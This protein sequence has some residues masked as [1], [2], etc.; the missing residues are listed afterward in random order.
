MALVRKFRKTT[1]PPVPERIEV[2]L[3]RLRADLTQLLDRTKGT[4]PTPRSIAVTVHAASLHALL[5]D[6]AEDD[7]V[8]AHLNPGRPVP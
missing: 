8:F 4:V 3:D 5:N 2:L 1:K 7:L 6:E